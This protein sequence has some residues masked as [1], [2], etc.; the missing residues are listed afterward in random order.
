MATRD[1]ERSRWLAPSEHPVRESAGRRP[2]PPPDT[3]APLVFDAR[4]S[5]WMATVIRPPATGENAMAGLGAELGHALGPGDLAALRE[6]G[7]GQGACLDGFECHVPS[8]RRKGDHDRHR[9]QAVP[10]IRMP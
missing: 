2:M 1:A 5:R 6:T 7:G 4:G 3:A 8:F 9:G 10:A